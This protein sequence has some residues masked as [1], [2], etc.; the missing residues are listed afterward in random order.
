MAVNAFFF[1]IR[2]PPAKSLAER[3]SAYAG[4]HLY[5]FICL[6]IF[7]RR[8]TAPAELIIAASADHPLW[9]N[10]HTG[11]PD[12]KK[13]NNSRDPSADKGRIYPNIDNYVAYSS[14]RKERR[15]AMRRRTNP[16]VV[17]ILNEIVRGI[18]TMLVDLELGSASTQR[19]SRAFL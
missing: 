4:R 3:C 8:V 11:R 7:H 17:V 19:C 13:S 6:S 14:K 16:R 18:K 15:T 9:V 12:G 2:N 10:A 1:I 5:L